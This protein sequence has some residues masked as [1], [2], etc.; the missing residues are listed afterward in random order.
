MLLACILHDPSLQQASDRYPWECSSLINMQYA[1][2]WLLVQV[3][4][5]ATACQSLSFLASDKYA[6]PS[7]DCDALPVQATMAPPPSVNAGLCLV[8]ASQLQLSHARHGICCP[9]APYGCR[10][11]WPCQCSSSGCLQST[12]NRMRVLC[13]ILRHPHPARLYCL[14]ALQRQLRQLVGMQQRL[15]L[16]TTSVR[17]TVRCRTQSPLQSQGLAPQ[18]PGW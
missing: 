9:M 3:S 18:Q 17:G 14:H 10:C 6:L 12:D 5:S 1:I 11:Q 16:C 2:A 15:L 8:T 13:N 7:T 4:S